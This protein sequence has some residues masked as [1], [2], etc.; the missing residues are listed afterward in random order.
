MRDKA[1]ATH[2]F[3]FADLVS[4]GAPHAVIGAVVCRLTAWTLPRIKGGD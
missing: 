4:A 3:G 1:A 2:T